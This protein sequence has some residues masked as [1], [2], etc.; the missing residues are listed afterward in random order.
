M[1]RAPG[2]FEAHLVRRRARGEVTDAADYAAR[3]L[4]VLDA[5]RLLLLGLSQ[6]V[7]AELAVESEAWAIIYRDGDIATAYP[8]RPDVPSF[9]AHRQGRGWRVGEVPIDDKVRDR[10]RQLRAR[11]A[12]LGPR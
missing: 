6:D 3:I 4:A 9:I 7:P 11:Y 8:R 5:P 2:Q 1:N 10:L 12:G